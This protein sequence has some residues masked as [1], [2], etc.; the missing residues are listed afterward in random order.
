MANPCNN[1][2][3]LI[4]LISRDLF[5]SLCQSIGMIIGIAPRDVPKTFP[6]EINDYLR[7]T[8][9]LRDQIKKSGSYFKKGTE[10]NQRGGNSRYRIRSSV[11]FRSCAYQNCLETKNI[12]IFKVRKIKNYLGLLGSPLVKTKKGQFLGGI[13]AMRRLICRKRLPLCPE[14]FDLM[15][16]GKLRFSN[17]SVTNK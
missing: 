9:D 17:L 16:A 8:A 7:V 15:K 1:I 4:H 10:T 13:E 3:S 14:H 6:I 11:L 12:K 2:N 5:H